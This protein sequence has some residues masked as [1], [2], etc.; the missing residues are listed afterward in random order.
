M[1]ETLKIR[2]SK[3]YTLNSHLHSSLFRR[4]C[5]QHQCSMFI[6]K[7]TSSWDEVTKRWTSTIFLNGIGKWKILSGLGKNIECVTL[8]TVLQSRRFW[9]RGVEETKTCLDIEA[10]MVARL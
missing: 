8:R 2:S 9:A 5:D 10:Y 4:K 1:N 6:S 7:T 3:F